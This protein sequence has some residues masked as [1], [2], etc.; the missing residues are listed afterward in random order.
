MSDFESFKENINK[1]FNN[2][3]EELKSF[4]A[5]PQDIPERHVKFANF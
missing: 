1:Q 3:A 4:R 5:I 2:L